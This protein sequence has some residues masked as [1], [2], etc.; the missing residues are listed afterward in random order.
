MDVAE[1][2]DAVIVKAEVPGVDPKD[3]EVTLTG[4][5]LTIK[6][7]KRE[8]KE[9]KGKRT[10]RIERAYGAFSRSI[11]LPEGVDPDNITAEC[12]D[13]VLTVTLPKK[14]EAK[15]RQIKVE[16]K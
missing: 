14:P 2:D 13:G 4:G 1:T 12:K 8:E 10:H 6:G 16:V 15:A 11:D 9:E 7:E 5:V 3:I